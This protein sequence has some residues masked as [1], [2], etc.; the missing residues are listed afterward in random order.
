MRSARSAVEARRTQA[1]E[2][3]THT[4]G[5]WPCDLGSQSVPSA[6]AMTAESLAS[7]MTAA[8]LPL[9]AGV[10]F[11]QSWPSF[12][13]IVEIVG[14]AAMVAVTCPEQGLRAT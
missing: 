7:V 4:S 5:A 8:H 6:C 13:S 11:C 9:T 1:L 10:V 12:S 2:S 14:F 3:G